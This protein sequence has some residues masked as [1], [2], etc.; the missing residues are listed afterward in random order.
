MAGSFLHN[1]SVRFNITGVGVLDLEM[2]S[3]DDV[4][5]TPIASL[6]MEVTPGREPRV[7]TDFISQGM[8]LKGSTDKI[9][10][11]MRINSICFYI[12]PIWSEFPY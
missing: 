1:A 11:V 12:K 3:L 10:E 2:H 9:N 8:K 6:A 5:I 7:L 4:V